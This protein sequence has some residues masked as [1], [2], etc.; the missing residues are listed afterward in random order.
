MAKFELFVDDNYHHM[1][2]EE[3]YLHGTYETYD[4]AVVSAKK[5]I[6]NFFA[7]PECRKRTAEQL[8][9]GWA[10]FGDN[11]FIVGDLSEAHVAEIKQQ[12]EA[13]IAEFE[14][15]K[16]E[17]GQN[18]HEMLKPFNLPPS[19]SFSASEYARECCKKLGLKEDDISKEEN[20][21]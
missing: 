8:F 19:R 18:L 20:G 21:Q 17:H 13:F 16:E 3:R 2:E 6:D 7:N 5:I 12:G 10:H 9:S 4:E 15:R 1:D 11:P 14:K